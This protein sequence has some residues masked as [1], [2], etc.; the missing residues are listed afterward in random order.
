MFRIDI[1]LVIQRPPIFLHM[2]QKDIDFVKMRSKIMNEYY[3]NL[4]DRIAEYDE[5]SI[6]NEDILAANPY[7]SQQNLDN[8]PTHEMEDPETGETLQYCAASK[9][10]ANVDPACPDQ[11]SLH[12]APE[13]RVYFIVQN[14]FTKEWE[15]PTGQI[16][17]GESFLRAK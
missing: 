5:V 9:N 8:F 10:F 7:A 17:F 16:F 15:F 11:Q 2:R 6:M 4:K 12:Y 14:R 1:G 3:I 13:D